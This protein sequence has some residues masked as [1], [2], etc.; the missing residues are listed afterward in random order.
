MVTANSGAVA[1]PHTPLNQE[2]FIIHYQILII[3]HRGLILSLKSFFG[4][5]FVP[6]VFVLN[7]LVSS[8]P[9]FLLE[10]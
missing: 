3:I 6:C 5:V 1:V 4:F 2:N 7:D 9:F 8:L 10:L